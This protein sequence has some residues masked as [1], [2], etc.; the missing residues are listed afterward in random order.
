M[1]EADSE[2]LRYIEDTAKGCDGAGEEAGGGAGGAGA[3]LAQSGAQTSSDLSAAK[4]SLAARKDKAMD[5][6]R[7]NGWEAL[8]S[9]ALEGQHLRARSIAC[10]DGQFAEGY[11]WM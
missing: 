10:H 8:Q 11:H 3:E 6:N 2:A 7:R 4:E 5:S 9:S 1:Q